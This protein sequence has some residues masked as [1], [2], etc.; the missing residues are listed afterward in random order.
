MK[1]IPGTE[2]NFSAGSIDETVEVKI[3]ENTGQLWVNKHDRRQDLSMIVKQANTLCLRNSKDDL[4]SC[5]VSELTKEVARIE[6]SKK[7]IEQYRG[8]MAGRLRNYTCSDDSMETTEPVKSY[9]YQFL[10][11]SYKVNVYLDTE[12]A[13]IWGIEDFLT[14]DECNRLISTSKDRLMKATVSGDDG[15]STYSETRKAQQA[16]YEFQGNMRSD[17]LW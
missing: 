6:E 11:K 17:E 5:I 8:L 12:N 4:K 2:A 16:G 3:D 15:G 1:H 7:L 9:N 14:D 13:K 10:G